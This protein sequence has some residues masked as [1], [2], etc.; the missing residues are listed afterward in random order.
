MMFAW[1][2]TLGIIIAAGGGIFLSSRKMGGIR[3]DG[4]PNQVP[5]GLVMVGCTLV[6]FLA[7]VHVINLAGFETGPEHGFFGRFR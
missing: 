4:R 6:L 5:W 2:I 1:I 7:M 3:R